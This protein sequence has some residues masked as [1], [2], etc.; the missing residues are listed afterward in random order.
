MVTIKK[1]NVITVT[2]LSRTETWVKFYNGLCDD[3]VGSCCTMPVEVKIV[4]L[5]RM[6]VVDEFDAVEPAKNIAKRLMKARIIEH[7]NFKNEIYTLARRS[8]NDCIYLDAQTR[9]CTIYENR[10]NTCRKHPQ[11]G[12]RP[13]HCAY[14]RKGI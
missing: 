5:I 4:D 8:N 3:C 2:D 10:P 9:R 13:G 6:G 14:N 11:V 7:F 12:P 1:R